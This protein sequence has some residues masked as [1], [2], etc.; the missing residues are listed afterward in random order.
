M[1]G[2]ERAVHQPHR[3]RRQQ[4]GGAAA[5]VAV[6]VAQHQMV[7]LAHAQ[8]AQQRQ[9]HPLAGVA[10]LALAAVGRSGVVQQIVA[11]G[12]HQHRMALADIGHDQLEMPGLRPL[13]RRPQQGQQHRHRQQTQRPGPGQR[14][15]HRRGQTQRLGPDRRRRRTPGRARPGQQ[16]LQHQAQQVDRPDR[17]Q[18]QRLEQQAQQRQRRHHQRDQRNRHQIGRQPDQ[19]DLLE[20]QQGPRRQAERGHP[21]AAQQGAQRLAQPRRPGLLRRSRAHPCAGRLRGD[22]QRHRDKGQPEAR[23]QQGPGIGQRN[24]RRHQRQQARHRPVARALAQQRHRGQHQHGALRRHAPARQQRVAQRRQHPAQTG[25]TRRRTHQHQPGPGPVPPQQRD[26][27]AGQPGE[28]RHMQAADRHQMTQAGQAEQRPVLALDRALVTQAQ[29]GDHPGRRPLAQHRKQMLAPV[30]APAV[31][32]GL[33][34]L[35]QQHRPVGRDAAALHHPALAAQA[36]LERTQRQVRPVQRCRRLD[37]PQPQRQSPALA[38]AWRPGPRR[39]SGQAAFAP[40]DLQPARQDQRHRRGRIRHACAAQGAGPAGT[41]HLD[42]ATPGALAPDR[43]ADDHAL[44]LHQPVLQRRIEPVAQAGLGTQIGQQQRDRCQREGTEN[45]RPAA[46]PAPCPQPD[47][48]QQ[49]QQQRGRQQGLALGRRQQA[50]LLELQQRARQHRT[51]RHAQRHHGRDPV[52]AADHP[53]SLF[54]SV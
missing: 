54:G 42:L 14:Q 45:P 10:G 20:E 49:E 39:R 8:A 36:L 18:P 51:G 43:Q 38:G 11:C 21:L 52:Q 4:R 48:R 5:V 33:A 16:R 15:Q 37:R 19:R 47:P 9:Q 2:L 1:A 30:L 25:R 26:Q 27:H 35:G 3:Q 22:Q 44:D 12:A 40:E 28:H 32:A 7:E 46:A 6:A 13:Q 50:R 17:R 23:L 41:L 31:D 29:A 34:G 24:H 53:P